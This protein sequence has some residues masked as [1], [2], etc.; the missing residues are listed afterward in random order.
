MR[1]SLSSS[2]TSSF[3]VCGKIGIS[4]M[5]F[6]AVEIESSSDEIFICIDT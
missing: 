5:F 1:K 3:L 2:G 6:L 4:F